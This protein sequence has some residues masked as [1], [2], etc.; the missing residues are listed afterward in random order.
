MVGG[1]RCKLWMKAGAA[2]CAVAEAMQMRQAQGK[3]C[4]CSDPPLNKSCWSTNR[5]VSYSAGPYGLQNRLYTLT[6]RPQ[7][8]DCTWPRFSSSSQ[9]RFENSPA[10][11]TLT[12][13]TFKGEEEEENGSSCLP[14]LGCLATYIGYAPCCVNLSMSEVV[15][16]L[17]QHFPY[18]FQV[19]I[20]RTEFEKGML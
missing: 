10:L 14:E 7:G 12:T 2:T 3:R 18:E 19:L 4:Y 13:S 16:T 5:P 6:N 15:S 20:L 1:K 11:C 17:L 8:L 9:V